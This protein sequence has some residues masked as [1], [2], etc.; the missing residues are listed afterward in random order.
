[1]IS[2]YDKYPVAI[3]GLRMSD[4]GHMCTCHM[5]LILMYVIYVMPFFHFA[6]WVGLKIHFQWCTNSQ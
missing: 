1:M 3:S 5:I 6:E 2:R 4:R